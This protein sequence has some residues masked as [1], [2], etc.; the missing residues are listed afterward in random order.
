VRSGGHGRGAASPAGCARPSPDPPFP[1][2]VAVGG[3]LPRMT[4][5][6]P[7]SDLRRPR[8]RGRRVCAGSVSLRSNAPGST[9]RGRR[10]ATS[11][12]RPGPPGR[13]RSGTPSGARIE[14]EVRTLAWTCPVCEK[15]NP[16]EANGLLHL[17]DPVRPAARGAQG[18][19]GG[20]AA[21]GGRVGR[22]S[23]PGSAIGSS[24]GGPDAFARSSRCSPGVRG[25]VILRRVALRQ[26]GL[27]P[28]FPL[29]SCSSAPR[30]MIYVC[31]RWTLPP[32]GPATRP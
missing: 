4:G 5:R 8:V 7:V 13:R 12:F 31:R 26:G 16:I 28:T 6:P 14:V 11:A 21:D 22:C 10:P 18:G 15:R 17:R 9:H 1:V 20:R 3:T 23:G 30:C 32:G 19:A 2:P 24:A 25:A 27:G 29:S